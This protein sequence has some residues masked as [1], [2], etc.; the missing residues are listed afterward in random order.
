MTQRLSEKD[1]T[2]Q[3]EQQWLEEEISRI[4]KDIYLVTKQITYFSEQ[5]EVNK[6]DDRYVNIGTQLSVTKTENI[7]YLSFLEQQLKELHPIVV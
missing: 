6:K 2:I 7:K 3:Q 1:I 4:R 5:S